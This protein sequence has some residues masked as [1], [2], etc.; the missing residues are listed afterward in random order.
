MKVSMD[1][2]RG[3]MITAYSK[4]VESLNDATIPGY[5]KENIADKMADLRQLIAG[6]CCVFCEGDPDFT[7][8]ADET[9]RLLRYDPFN[10]YGE[11]D[12]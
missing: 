5:D 2:L 8:M 12:E 6:L 3:H 11:E 9:N 10:E 7:N 1:G 4:V